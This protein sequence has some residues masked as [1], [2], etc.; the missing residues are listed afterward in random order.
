MAEKITKSL[1]PIYGSIQRLKTR[2]TNLVTFCEDKVLKVLASKDALFNADGNSNLTATDRVLGTAIPFVGDYGISKNPESMATDTYRMYFAD[3]QR[4]AVLRLSGDGLTPIS[5]VGMKT[6]FRENLPKCENII[7]TY[8]V[9]NGEYN[10]TLSLNEVHQGETVCTPAGCTVAAEPQTVTFN[11]GGKAWVSFKSFVHACG[12]SISGQYFT[13]PLPYHRGD[14]TASAEQDRSAE[15]NNQLY[16]PLIKIWM[17]HSTAVNRN[18]FYDTNFNSE[19]EVTFNE[20]PDMIKSFRAI[21]YE[22]SQA[23]VQEFVQ[24]TGHDVE[25]N[26]VIFTDGNYYNLTGQSGWKIQSFNTD[27]QSGFVPEFIQKENK[28]FNFIHGG[29]ATVNNLDTTAITG[30]AAALNIQGIGFFLEDPADTQTD[31]T[32]DIEGNNPQI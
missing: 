19:I 24:T 20:M 27:L 9:V 3:K 16:S 28:W 10:L 26:S 7:G 18:S 29:V 32:I 1:N 17:H 23:V 5:N 21:N 13:A 22:G 6:W 4:G 15:Y 14:K 31:A 30:N 8:D 12:E 2:D 25:G 11:E